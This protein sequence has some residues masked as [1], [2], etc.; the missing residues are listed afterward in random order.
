MWRNSNR[1]VDRLQRSESGTPTSLCA[2]D[3]KHGGI[4]KTYLSSII[5]TTL[6]ATTPI[7][8]ILMLAPYCANVLMT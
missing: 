8:G 7:W 3:L 1:S 2:F 5:T 4:G 6:R